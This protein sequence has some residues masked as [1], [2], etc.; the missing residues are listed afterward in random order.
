MIDERILA[1][2][3]IATAALIAVLVGLTLTLVNK[4]LE[5]TTRR[6]FVVLFA[7]LTVYVICDLLSQITLMLP[8][9][10][11]CTRIMIFLESAS[12]S[13][14]MPVLTVMLICSYGG[15]YL[16]SPLYYTVVALYMVYFALLIITQFT[17]EIYYIT[18]DNEYV[19]GPYYAVLLVRFK[20]ELIVSFDTPHTDFRLPPLTLQPIV[21]NAV[22]HS[23]KSEL[24]P[25]HINIITRKTEN[26]SEVIVE[27]TG[28]GFAEVDNGEPHIALKNIVERLRMMCGGT[29]TISPH[30][31]GG[32][33]VTLMIPQK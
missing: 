10:A 27:D 18:P 26:G 8:G 32:T 3:C 19:R 12:S 4:M 9:C 31:G 15:T 30:E 17:T 5:K 20:D 6:W 28:P 25:T 33:R 11:P 29:L 1:N 2:C 16:K 23:V 21:E 24:D 13:A 22:K 7:I 14:A